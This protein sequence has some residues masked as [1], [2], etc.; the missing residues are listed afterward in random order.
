MTSVSDIEIDKETN[1]MIVSSHGR[2]IYKLNLNPIHYYFMDQENLKNDKILNTAKFILPKFNDTHREPIMNTYEKAPISFY[3]NK[4]KE[5]SLII[6][7][8]KEILWKFNGIGKKGLNQFRWDLIIE[9]NNSQKPYHIHF[10]KFINA[11]NYTLIL[12]TDG[13]LHDVVIEVNEFN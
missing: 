1:D 8:D 6:K 5:Y 9:K 11:G 3:L 2:G 10:N 4:E 7:N 13:N 12:K